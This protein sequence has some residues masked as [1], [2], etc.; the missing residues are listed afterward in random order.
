VEMHPPCLGGI[1][2]DIESVGAGSTLQYRPQV[3]RRSMDLV[4]MREIQESKR[5]TMLV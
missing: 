5:M 1:W 3:S 4:V 2:W